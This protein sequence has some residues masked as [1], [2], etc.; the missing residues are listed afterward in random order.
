MGIN[1]PLV[2]Y[3]M[4][5][6][7]H[8]LGMY[9]RKQTCPLFDNI[10]YQI[11]ILMTLS[12]TLE[13]NVSIKNRYLRKFHRICITGFLKSHIIASIITS[14]FT[15]LITCNIFPQNATVSEIKDQSQISI[16]KQKQNIYCYCKYFTPQNVYILHRISKRT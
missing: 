16:N 11:V 13:L 14:S 5:V 9:F 6:L 2:L 12:R 8:S 1:G 10:T 4:T 15:H 3:K 7:S